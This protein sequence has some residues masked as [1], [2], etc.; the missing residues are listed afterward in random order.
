MVKKKA[1]RPRCIVIA[2]PNGAGK[3]TLAR[4]LLGNAAVTIRFVNADLIAAGLSPLRPDS[5][6]VQAGKLL[7]SEIDRLAKNRE[8][9][10]FETT[11]SG[12]GHAKRLL[13]LKAQGYQ[14]TIIFIQLNSPRLALRR[15]E[16]RVRQGGHGVPKADILR[17]FARGL[18]NFSD[19]YC[20]IADS[21][22]VYDNSGEYPRLLESGP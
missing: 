1:R 14:I 9:F 3:T 17:R 16:S 18:R 19:I 7:L 13:E 4:E 6:A 22:V 21:W 8:D 10:A 15:V 20:L 12:K 5:A 11:L 2:G